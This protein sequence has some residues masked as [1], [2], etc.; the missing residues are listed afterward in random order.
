VTDL[1]NTGVIKNGFIFR[2]AMELKLKFKGEKHIKY[3]EYEFRHSDRVL[4]VVDK[5]RDNEVYY[6]SVTFPEGLSNRSIFRIIENND[7]LSGEMPS[8]ESIGEGTLLAETYYFRRG[9]SRNSII[10]RMQRGMENFINESWDRRYQNPLIRTKYEALILASMVEKESG[11]FF[12]KKLTASVFL[13][14]LAKN[15]Y[16]QSDPTAIYSY[17][18]GDVEKEKKMKTSVL[19]REKTPYN[20]YRTKGLPPAP[21]CN[22]SRESLLA[23]LQPVKS[24][25]LFFV[26]NG[27]GGHNFSVSYAEHRKFVNELRKKNGGAV[28]QP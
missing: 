7:F 14:R 20:T 18:R 8:E 15:M 21:I 5:I 25:Y 13:N 11:N 12:E 10:E 24:D 4:D 3:G 16:L 19:L 9:D 17:A 27:N 1:K 6:R 2:I 28:K 23:V 22:P 26:S